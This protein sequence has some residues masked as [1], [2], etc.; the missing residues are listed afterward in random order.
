VWGA[1]P[2]RDGRRVELVRDGDVV[3]RGDMVMAPPVFRGNEVEWALKRGK[4]VRRV[5]VD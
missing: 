2:D 4:S 3:A 5:I 1:S